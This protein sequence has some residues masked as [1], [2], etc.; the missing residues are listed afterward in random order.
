MGSGYGTDPLQAAL[1]STVPVSTEAICTAA[2]SSIG[3]EVLPVGVAVT[4][5]A[6]STS[7]VGCALALAAHREHGQLVTVLLSSPAPVSGR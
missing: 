7:P 6:P 1:S 2:M 4:P 3:I 5:R